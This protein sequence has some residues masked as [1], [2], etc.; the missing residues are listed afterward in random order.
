MAAPEEL[1]GQKL[2]E[3]R[4]K[5]FPK[6][7]D[8]SFR[9]L[10]WA[11]MAVTLTVYYLTP[12]LRWDRGPYA[13]DQAVLVDLANRRFFMFSIEIWPHE[14]YYVAG[15]L[16][17]AGIGLFLVTSAVGRAWCGYACPQTVWT[18]LFVHV[19]RFVDG[20]RNAQVRL[21]NA[22]WTPSKIARRVVKHGIWLLIAIATG[23]AW[24]FYFADAPTLA[25]ALFAG[26][27]PFVAY[28]TIGVLTATTYLLG[29]LLRE[30]VCIY[31]CPWPRIQGAMLDEKSLLVTYKYWRGEPRTH[32][33]KRGGP[34]V[35]RPEEADP[36]AE[37]QHGLPSLVALAANPNKLPQVGDCIDCNACVAVC[38]T[39][40]DIREGSQIG[41]ITCGLC[42]DACDDVMAKIGRPPK[43]IG[44][45]TVLD[46]TLAAEGKTPEPP[47]KRLFRLRT[48]LYFLVWAAIG[49]GML[50]AL[51]QRTRVDLSVQQGRN[52][53]WVRLSDGSIRNA[54]TVKIRNMQARPRAM[55]I[56]I[57]KLAGAVMWTEAGR[58]EAAGKT[59]RV[60]VAADR[61]ATTR[62]FVAAPPSAEVREP[63]VFAVRVLDR[64]GGGDREESF[65]ERPGGGS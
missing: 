23:G 46:A 45:T 36:G 21:Q 43:L 31:M 10:K 42:I 60:D 58:R 13:A 65:F 1:T 54:Y 63:L 17:M 59:V 12:W 30:Q 5:V 38:P 48:T 19:E 35:R 26:E 39:G 29:G 25:R 6:K 51:G 49:L 50:F 4:R 11:V 33:T 18:D 52:P 40:I 64:E 56:G 41:C 9:R 20:D 22:P 37:A 14:F 24:I 27:A 2:F 16:I 62:L 47:L 61:V 15:L 44:Y 57:E 8:G 53:T 28:A 55:E 7:V 32:G 34:V 3:A